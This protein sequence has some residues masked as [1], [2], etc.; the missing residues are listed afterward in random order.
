MPG[1]WMSRSSTSGAASP[2]RRRAS[3]TEPVAR[4]RRYP[5]LPSISVF[6][7]SRSR[8]SSSTIPTWMSD[9]F[10]ASLIAQYSYQE[11]AP[12]RTACSCE[13][14][15]CEGHPNRNSRA[16]PWPGAG[17]GVAAERLRPLPEAAQ[18]AAASRRALRG[19]LQADAV[20]LD[21]PEHLA[22]A[23]LDVDSRQTAPRVA[24]RVVNRLLEHQVEAPPRL[25]RQ[26]DAGGVGGRVELQPHPLRL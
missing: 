1:R 10:G 11:R 16:A 14:Q 19:R 24:G 15:S 2:R 23:H 22:V 26:R 5:G 3:S 7:L 20:V 6:R 13:G 12:R 9:S 8:R 21:H 18:A 25:G 4:A 17:G